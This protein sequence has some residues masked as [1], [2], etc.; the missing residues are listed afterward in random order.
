MGRA[1]ATAAT[2]AASL[3]ALGRHFNRHIICFLSCR[4]FNLVNSFRIKQDLSASP[5]T[6]LVHYQANLIQ[7]KL[8]TC[9]AKG[10]SFLGSP[11]LG[12]R[13]RG[14]AAAA[15]ALFVEELLEQGRGHDAAAAAAA[16]AVALGGPAAQRAAGSDGRGGG[17]IAAAAAARPL[18]L[19]GA[20]AA[21][22]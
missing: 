12:K 1:A 20:R 15:A 7:V 4:L 16:P 21:A 2:A 3:T 8:R 9:P 14:A 6:I 19:A 22:E 18:S 17:A 13:R 11:A 5:F 10:G